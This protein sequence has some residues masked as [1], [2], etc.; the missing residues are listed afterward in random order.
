MSD[1]T[2]TTPAVLIAL[3]LAAMT[4]FFIGFYGDHFHLGIPGEWIWGTPDVWKHDT[5]AWPLFLPAG[6]V[7]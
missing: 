4:A 2:W 5:A 7:L 6:V 3:S 1:R